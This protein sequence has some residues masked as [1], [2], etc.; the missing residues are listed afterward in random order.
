MKLLVISS[1]PILY[2]EDGPHAYAPYAAE[3]KIW[4]KAAGE[5]MMCCPIWDS[6]NPL[7]TSKLA[8]PLSS[9]YR[10]ADF[11]FTSMGQVFK[12]LFIMPYNFALI[13]M[14]MFRADHIHLRCPGNLGL[15]ACVAQIFFPFKK[16]V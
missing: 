13:V 12:A 15:L 14:A 10:T 11:S 16:G 6:E 5:I 7:L 8:F 2:K 9:H 4:A 1:A 3:L